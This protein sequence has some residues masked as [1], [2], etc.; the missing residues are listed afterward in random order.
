MTTTAWAH[1][2]NAEHIDRILASSKA[3]PDKWAAASAAYSAAYSTAWDAVWDVAYSAVYSA[4]QSAARETARYSA[5][6]G[7]ILALVAGDDC[8]YMLELPEDTLTVLRAVGNQQAL[9]LSVAA[10]ILRE[11]S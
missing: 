4:A 10:K 8:A 9:L 3:H 11:T 7:A 2:P 6:R 1:L 5:A